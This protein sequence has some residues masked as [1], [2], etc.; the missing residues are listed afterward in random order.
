MAE[1][2]RLE[3]QL[4]QLT[5]QLAQLNTTTKEQ[6]KQA[7]LGGN[8]NP[9][10]SAYA[11]PAYS[12]SMGIDGSGNE[13]PFRL[14]KVKGKLNP[15]S[16]NRLSGPIAETSQLLYV[17]PQDR[18]RSDTNEV[19]GIGRKAFGFGEAGSGLLGGKAG[20]AMGSAIG[21][22][23]AAK[24]GGISGGALSTLLAGGGWLAGGAIGAT[25]GAVAFK[26]LSGTNQRIA[27]NTLHKYTMENSFRFMNPNQSSGT[28][29]PLGAGFGYKDSRELSRN[30]ALMTDDTNLNVKTLMDLTKNFTE[31]D[32]MKGVNSTKDFTK[33]FKSLTETAKTMAYLL[34]D[35]IEDAGKF[36][37]DLQLRGF[38]MSK[39]ANQTAKM[40]NLSQ[41]LGKDVGEVAQNTANYASNSTAGTN[42]DY[43]NAFSNQIFSAE[44]MNQIQDNYLKGGDQRY[45][46]GY[47]IVKNMNGPEEAAAVLSKVLTSSLASED[48]LLNVVQMA[49]VDFDPVTKTFSHNSRKQDRFLEMGLSPGDA[50]AFGQNNVHREYVEKMRTIDPNF[51]ASLDLSMNAFF[52]DKQKITGG[53]S[54]E[55]QLSAMKGQIDMVRSEV[56]DGLQGMSDSQILQASQFNYDETTADLLAASIAALDGGFEGRRNNRGLTALYAAEQKG[57]NT[58]FLGKVKQFGAGIGN[59]IAG[60]GM[61]ITS[62]IQDFADK[63]VKGGSDF[64]FGNKDF[65]YQEEFGIDKETAQ[66]W[67]GDSEGN[68][69][70]SKIGADFYKEFEKGLKDAQKKGVAISAILMKEVSEMAKVAVKATASEVLSGEDYRVK[71]WTNNEGLGEYAT[72]NYDDI[73]KAAV[74]N[75][76]SDQ[77][78]AYIGTTRNLNPSQ[79]KAAATDLSRF[80]EDYGGN[81]TLGIAAMEG[82]QDKLDAALSKIFP[83][84]DLLKA[85]ETKDFTAFNRNEGILEFSRDYAK[86]MEEKVGNAS[87][88]QGSSGVM[89]SKSASKIVEEKES[90]YTDSLIGAIDLV[91][92]GL[93][94]A[95]GDSIL[96]ARL[97]AAGIEVTEGMSSSE[98]EGLLSIKENAYADNI[99][100]LKSYTES[101][102]NRAFLALSEVDRKRT[103]DVYLSQMAG[104]DKLNG[105][106]R[107]AF[108]SIKKNYDA[109]VTGKSISGSSWGLSGVHLSEAASADYESINASTIEEM[110]KAAAAD[111]QK[112]SEGAKAWQHSAKQTIDNLKFKGKT[113]EE[114]ADARMKLMSAVSAGDVDQITSLGDKYGLN[115][116]WIGELK[117]IA[118]AKIEGTDI[119]ALSLDPEVEKDRNT[120]DT[121]ALVNR[122]RYDYNEAQMLLKQ[123]GMDQSDID[124]ISISDEQFDKTSLKAIKANRD[125]LIDK[126]VAGVAALSDAELTNLVKSGVLSDEE[127][128]VLTQDDGSGKSALKINGDG[129]YSLSKTNTADA[130]RQLVELAGEE[131]DPSFENEKKDKEASMN[132]DEAASNLLT[133]AE[134]TT[135]VMIDGTKVLIDR[136]NELAKLTGVQL[137]STT[138]SGSGATSN[139]SY[140]DD[141]GGS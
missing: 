65:N 76:I 98:K 107:K 96:D 63:A 104:K 13:G 140:A 50:L 10:S 71:R 136:Q 94:K 35:S 100:N 64:L 36:M 27:A 60:A 125:A 126:A 114:T 87:E 34:N 47:N 70:P 116:A 83:K 73:Q 17:S 8:Y 53:M 3:N 30:I 77:T 48:S 18:I 79:L 46:T 106:E 84:E 39:L 95:T 15:F 12:A 66:K 2:S 5:E 25:A 57:R 31:G 80:V 110:E 86:K 133:T 119:R 118:T 23:I 141:F 81:E 62:P 33:R 29:N 91:S 11:A 52:A 24:L 1:T 121:N 102:S 20:M 75:K 78:L 67:F 28:T 21:A 130:A 127:I 37:S 74:D 90:S 131:Y 97:Q 108:D 41:F 42:M 56:P 122:V 14:D 111:D 120:K 61:A 7:K 105:S 123:L 40:K 9:F 89:Q 101:G 4:S 88:Y 128:E 43:T 109:I 69:D 132:L 59:A 124:K 113:A 51:E 138:S 16:H 55:D 49:S 115:D 32:L 58:G 68:I 6:F 85:R 19:S 99:K 103:I 22:G 45:K 26:T 135:K 72:K 93:P 92:A 54:G 117:T 82:G 129:T 112:F 139:K 134:N 44:L 137:P 38:D